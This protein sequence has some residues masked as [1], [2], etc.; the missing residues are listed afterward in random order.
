MDRDGFRPAWPLTRLRRC[1][2]DKSQ[3]KAILSILK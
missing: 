2:E 1:D 3:A